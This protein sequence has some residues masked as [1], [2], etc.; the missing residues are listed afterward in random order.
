[1]EPTAEPRSGRPGGP[2][3]APGDRVPWDHEALPRRRRERPRR[4]RGARGRGA[5]AARRERRRQEHALE[6]LHRPLPRRRGRARGLRRA[7][8]P[9][10]P[11][12]TGSTR[13]S[14][15][16]TSTS[17][18]WS[19]SPSPR[20]SCSA[21]TATSAARSASTRARSRSAWPSSASATG[22]PSTR[23]ARIWQLSVGE[24]Q[25]VEILK[26]L[27]REARILILDEPTAVLTPAGGGGAVRDAAGDG[28]RRAHRHLHLAQAARGDGG[29][30]PRHRAARRPL[31]RHRRDRGARTLQSLA[32]LMV[33]RE[34]HT[35]RR[36]G[37]GSGR[38]ASCCSSSTG[39]RREGDRGVEAVHD[40]SLKVR[41]GRDPRRRRRRRQR[42][43]RAGRGGHRACARSRRA[44]IRVGGVPLHTGDPRAA[45]KA[46]IAHVPEDRLHTGVAPSLSISSNVVLKSYRSDENSAGP[47][48]RFHHI[49]DWAVELIRRYD[50]KAPGPERIGPPALGRQPAEGRARARVLG[51]AAR[52]RD[53]GADA[54]ARRR[55]DRDRARAPARGGRGRRRDPAHLARTSTS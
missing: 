35:Y 49:R 23:A 46:G 10:T 6:H 34:L 2:W 24:Q 36:A 40:V 50:V 25:R 20:T 15:W 21:T 43:A 38:S 14:G 8:S 16:C 22:W 44:S 30:R 32:A 54:R 53:R 7:R 48:L 31:G 1:M 5:R 37:R 51:R 13:G 41:A 39:C 45:I 33:G 4:L 47:F 28:G 42:A 18:S 3:C 12:A 26:A 17:G 27:Y 19:R 52:A 9:S 29:L 55:R 11:R